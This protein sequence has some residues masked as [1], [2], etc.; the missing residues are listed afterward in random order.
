MLGLD[1][2]LV[3]VGCPKVGSLAADFT[4]AHPQRVSALVMVCSS[5]SGLELD[6]LE[7]EIFQEVEVSDEAGD[8]DR[9]GELET[10][11]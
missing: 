11:T 6:V 7:P 4:L 8:W 3:I 2:P 1:G 5:T 10:H 9:I